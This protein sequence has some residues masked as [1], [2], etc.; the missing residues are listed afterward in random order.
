MGLML[1]IHLI[2]KKNRWSGQIDDHGEINNVE[3]MVS[4]NYFRNFWRTLEI[5]LINC[6]VNL[7]LT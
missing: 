6:E 3:I 4:L 1:L 5:P 2:L 7:V